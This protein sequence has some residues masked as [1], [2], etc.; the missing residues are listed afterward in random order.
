[1]SWND[2]GESHYLAPTAVSQVQAAYSGYSWNTRQPH[3]A[4]WT[5]I[6]P[7]LAAYRKGSTSLTPHIGCAVPCVTVLTHAAQRE[8]PTGTG[9]RRRTSS[10]RTI[11]SACRT[12]PVRR[13]SCRAAKPSAWTADSVWAAAVI[14]SP[15]NLTITSGNNTRTT[16]MQPGISYTSV[17]MGAGVPSFV[18]TRGNVVVARGAGNKSISMTDCDPSG[19][20]QF[21]ACARL[22]HCRSDARQLRRRDRGHAGR[23]VVPREARDDQEGQQVRARGDLSCSVGILHSV[24]RSSVRTASLS[25]LA[26]LRF[27]SSQQAL[28]RRVV[29]AAGPPPSCPVLPRYAHVRAPGQSADPW[30]DDDCGQ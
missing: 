6:Q 12:M 13:S 25:L 30:P 11:R 7:F 29:V 26:R 20:Y 5:V 24:G 15:A 22:A 1:M 9:R 23:Y 18:L 14:K 27:A 17:P 10:A 3:E 16:L 4:W 21:N 8:S 2:F 28:A 19:F